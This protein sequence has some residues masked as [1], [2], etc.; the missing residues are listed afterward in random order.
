MLPLPSD[1]LSMLMFYQ[2]FK[3]HSSPSFV[4]MPMKHHAMGTQ[5]FWRASSDLFLVECVNLSFI[6]KQKPSRSR[7]ENR[8]VMSA[9]LETCHGE[10]WRHSEPQLVSLAVKRWTP[11]EPGG[12]S[13]V[14]VTKPASLVTVQLTRALV[15][16]ISPPVESQVSSQIGCW[17][18]ELLRSWGGRI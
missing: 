15:R 6:N 4:W 1:Q 8:R 3:A 10:S 13:S 11:N 16:D 18:P 5:C 2:A 14:L 9:T 17:P 7:P 12:C